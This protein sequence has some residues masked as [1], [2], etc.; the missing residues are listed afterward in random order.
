MLTCTFNGW[1]KGRIPSKR[2][3]PTFLRN[4]CFKG[5][6]AL[7]RYFT[8]LCVGLRCSV[9]RGYQV[10]KQVCAAC[11]SMEYLCYRNL[12]GVIMDEAEA[13]REA[14]DVSNM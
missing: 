12:V 10:Y 3:P 9:R 1:T 14:E 6:W 13:K 11:H 5:G 4:L 7:T 8:V 2:P